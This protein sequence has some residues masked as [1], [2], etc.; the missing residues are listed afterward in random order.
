MTPQEVM[1]EKFIEI[2]EKGSIPWRQPWQSRKKGLAENIVSNKKYTGCNFF[3]TNLQEFNSAKWGTYKQFKKLGGN[4]KKGEKGTPIIFYTR[5]EKENKDNEKEND[6]SSIPYCKLSYI[7]NLD[8]VDGIQID[9]K[10]KIKLKN[11]DPIEFCE[12]VIKEFPLGFPKAQYKEDR[13]FY[14]PS[15]DTINM[16]EQGLFS[17]IQ[18]YYHTYF[19]E[20]VHATGHENRL[21]REGVINSNYFGNELYSKEELIAEL[22]ASY[23]SAH[24]EID[25]DIIENSSSYIAGWL[26]LLKENPRYIT[27]CSAKAWQAYQYLI[28]EV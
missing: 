6:K 22:G 18:D 24:C 26:K 11:H 5:I 12:N 15:T 2:L 9:E 1:N 25:N 10:Q 28:K 8:Q 21:K 17:K 13:A 16:P 20:S 7:F 23:L 4:V 14:R 3:I 27:Q 19:H